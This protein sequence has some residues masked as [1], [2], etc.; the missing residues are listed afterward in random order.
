MARMARGKVMVFSRRKDKSQ[1]SFIVRE[2]F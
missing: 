1:A 2:S